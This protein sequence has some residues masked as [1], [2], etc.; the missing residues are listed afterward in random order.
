VELRHLRY[1]V[2]VAEELNFGRAAQRLGIA[3]PPLSQQIRR[4]E[5][6]FGVELFRRNRRRVQLTDAGRMLLERAK[7]L[8]VDADGLDDFMRSVASGERGRLTVGFVTSAGYE[9]LPAVVRTFRTRWPGV[10]VK[11]AAMSS[12]DLAEAVRGGQ[13]DVALIRLPVDDHRL[14]LTPLFE[15]RL[16]AALP[17]GHPLAATR[18]VNVAALGDEPFVLFP[19]EVGVAL[20]DDIIGICREAG[21]RPRIVQEAPDTTSWVS[22]VAAGIGVSL[23]PES[24]ATFRAPFV[25]Y[26]PLAGAPATFSVVLAERIDERSPLVAS[27]R[28]IAEEMQARAAAVSANGRFDIT[29]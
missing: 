1:F 27:F 6:E 22:L 17:D 23:V 11:L 4:L 14:R 26:R 15:E 7:P 20:Y 2:A 9:V 3:Q 18:S 25:T 29:V 13:A 16:L 21:F 28:T 10:D 8:L 12:H 24:V 19:R 5:A